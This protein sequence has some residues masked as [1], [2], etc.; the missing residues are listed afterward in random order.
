VNALVWREHLRNGFTILTSDAEAYLD[1]IRDLRQR[2]D[3]KQHE[4]ELIDQIQRDPDGTPSDRAPLSADIKREWCA[5][6]DENAYVTLNEMVY[7][8]GRLVSYFPHIGS[9]LANRFAY[10]L[11]DEFQDSSP[12]QVLILREIHRYGRTIFFCVGD[13]NQSIYRFARVSPELLSDFALEIVAST[14]L[15]LTANFRSSSHICAH[16]ERLCASNPPMRTA[17]IKGMYLPR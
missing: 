4:V 9:A 3:L 11:V 7:Y 13:S 8:A 10:I 17:E 6:L 12:S 1:K 2:Y 14:D 5:W 15:R 16:A